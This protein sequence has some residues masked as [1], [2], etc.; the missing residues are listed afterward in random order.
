MAARRLAV[1]GGLLVLG[2]TGH[3]G[4]TTLGIDGERFTLGGKPAFLLGVSYYGGLGAPPDAV[5]ADLDDLA[6]MGINWIRLWVTWGAG[7]A[8]VSAV[9]SEGALRQPYATRLVDLVREADERGIV[10]DVTY[11]RGEGL[12]TLPAHERAVRA[13]AELL[14]DWRNVYIDLANERNVGDARYVSFDGLAV[15]RQAVREADPERLV[16]AS[17]GGDIAEDELRGYV[18]TAGVDFIAP[19]RPRH[20]GSP[21]ETEAKTRWYREQLAAMG[22]PMPVHYQEPFRR[23]YGDW[24]PGAADFIADLDAAVAG[25]AAGWCL[26]NGSPR[27][28]AAGPARS[29]DLRPPNRRLLEQLDDEELGALKDMAACVVGNG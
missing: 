4:A 5:R 8:D 14:R 3:A 9:D 26:H 18:E 2:V 19:H 6:R 12:S 20:A 16:T 10:V 15:L 7:E 23:D 21:A 25:G 13:V 29:F 27:G 17:Q 24:Q 28:G 1:A 11:T 22:K